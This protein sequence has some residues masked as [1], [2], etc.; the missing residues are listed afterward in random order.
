VDVIVTSGPP[1]IQAARHATSAIPIVMGRMDDA[2]AHGFVASLARPGGNITGLSFQSGELSAKSLGLLREAVPRLARAAVLWDPAG[3]AQQ[4]QAVE[5]AAHALGVQVQVLEVHGPGD[6]DGAFDAARRGRA[7]ALVILAS[8]VLTDSR[9]RLAELALRS[10][11]PAVYYH[12]GFAEAGGLLAYGPRQSE[13]SWRRAAAFVDKILR[14][15]RPADLPV[16]Q[17]TTFELVVN[18]KAAK[19]LGLSLPRSLLLRADRV[20]P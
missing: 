16:E 20:I 2:D 12:P 9:A 17:P 15:A 7:G 18:L 11:L 14:G 10:R 19:R 6:L 1:A 13:F 3:T 5:A 8:P 4:L